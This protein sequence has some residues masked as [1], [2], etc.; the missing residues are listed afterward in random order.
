M[1]A[2][3]IVA[4]PRSTYL[5]PL[6]VDCSVLAALLFNEPQRGEAAEAMTGKALYAPGLIDHEVIS[7][8]LKKLAGGLDE[9]VGEAIRD[10]EQIRLT[11]C[12]TDQS[13]Q[14]ALAANEGLSAYDAAYLQLAVEL[15]APLATF[16][17]KLGKAAKHLL[18]N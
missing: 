17:Q 13:A 10:L 12:A 18:G 1:S 5:P 6:V 11:R 7:V 4:E 3:L 14:L 9:L 16:D 2:D 15:K 8:A